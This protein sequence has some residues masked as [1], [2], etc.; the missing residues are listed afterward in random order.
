MPRL[1]NEKML[2]EMCPNA[3][4]AVCQHI[5]SQ[6]LQRFLFPFYSALITGEF[7]AAIVT[8]R[9]GEETWGPASKAEGWLSWHLTSLL[10]G[11]V[12]YIWII[13]FQKDRYFQRGTSPFH[14]KWRRKK[15]GI[16]ISSWLFMSA[17]WNFAH[18]FFTLW[19][20]LNLVK[21]LGQRAEF[22]TTYDT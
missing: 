15:V 18:W 16:L 6:T 13:Y 7:A 8:W 4:F 9:M 3:F 12:V 22:Y 11:W 14:P 21:C 1:L 10:C 2:A 20:P 5:P 17:N 19:S